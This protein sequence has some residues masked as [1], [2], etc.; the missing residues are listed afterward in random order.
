MKNHAEEFSGMVKNSDRL[1][2]LRNKKVFTAWFYMDI[3][4]P[5]QG[6]SGM[7]AR[8]ALLQ[9]YPVRQKQAGYPAFV[10][11]RKPSPEE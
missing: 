11:R 4:V 8:P 2:M 3:L 1:S 6:D 10:T 9:Y 5:D 7:A